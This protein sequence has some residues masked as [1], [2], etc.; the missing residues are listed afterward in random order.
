MSETKVLTTRL[1]VKD[2][3][4]NSTL[5]KNSTFTKIKLTTVFFSNSNIIALEAILCFG[6]QSHF[7]LSYCIEEL[8]KY[9]KRTT[10]LSFYNLKGEV[11][12]DRG[13]FIVPVLSP[14]TPTCRYG[15]RT[16]AYLNHMYQ[17]AL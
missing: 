8:L 7:R 17:S 13:A 11:S 12:H 3:R 2:R 1:F 9:F 6:I 15:K 16:L 5:L 10:F 14:T 4:A